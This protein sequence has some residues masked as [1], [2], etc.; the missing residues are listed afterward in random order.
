MSKAEIL[1]EL[2]KLGLQERRE[3]FERIGELEDQD[4]LKGG[5]PSAED[6]ALLDRELEEYRRNPEAGSTWL[7]VE[8]RLRKLTRP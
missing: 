8:S 4:L 2:P 5:E 6:K 3:I 1:H 7:E